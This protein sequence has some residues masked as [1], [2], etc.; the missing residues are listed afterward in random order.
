MNQF[1]QGSNENF[2]DNFSAEQETKREQFFDKIITIPVSK[3]EFLQIGKQNHPEMEDAEILQTKGLNF[4]KDGEI[5]ILMR[6]DIYPEKYM[7][8]LET[9]EKWEAWVAR[10]GGYNLFK[11]SVREYKDDKGVENFDDKTKQEFY[12]ELSIYNYDFRHEYAIYKE[13]EQAMGDGKLDEYHR[14]IMDLREGEKKTAN[15]K[16]LQLIANDTRI[17]ESVYKKLTEGSKHYFTRN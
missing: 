16:T 10:K 4:E 5:V 17:R 6:T 1:E 13:Y 15:E 12:D 11:K 7:P 14:W 9:H 2:D 8:Y 3:E